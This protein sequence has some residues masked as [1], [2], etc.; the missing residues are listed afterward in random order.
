[1][2]C[3]N[4]M[5]SPIRQTDERWVSLESWVEW[6]LSL[7]RLTSCVFM[8]WGPHLTRHHFCYSDL[9][10]LCFCWFLCVAVHRVFTQ[11][12]KHALFMV[13]SVPTLQHNTSTAL[14]PQ[15]GEQ[16]ERSSETAPKLQNS[17]DCCQTPINSLIQCFHAKSLLNKQMIKIQNKTDDRKA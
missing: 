16:L 6:H 11:T 5:L 4:W 13:S 15:V 14:V 7:L 10:F 3:K 9:Y 2:S 12:V 17:C 8:S 1:M